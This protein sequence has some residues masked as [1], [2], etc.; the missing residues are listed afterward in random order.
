MTTERTSTVTVGPPGAQV[1]LALPVRG[2][3]RWLTSWIRQPELDATEQ[4]DLLHQW[5]GIEDRITL[6][7]S[8]YTL[9]TTAWLLAGL[10]RKLQDA[11]P[12]AE[13][14]AQVLC[15]DLS[16]PLAIWNRRRAGDRKYWALK[17]KDADIGLQLL[18]RLRKQ[19]DW[20]QF[21]QAPHPF[22]PCVKLIMVQDT[23]ALFGLYVVSRHRKDAI[24]CTDYLGTQTRLV[25]IGSSG[26]R[27]TA[28][29][30]FGALLRWFD[31]TWNQYAI[32][33]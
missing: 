10:L 13:L 25:A 15:P 27:G 32:A 11:R 4:L 28:Q 29:G 12:R 20:F 14:D 9:Q 3:F 17:R 22:D 18:D 30:A 16:K 5:A 33:P 26:G 1:T 6:K 21:R 23:R 19:Y 24:V 31:Q 8:C 7:I 2:L